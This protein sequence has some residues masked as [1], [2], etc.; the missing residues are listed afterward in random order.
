[1]N[2]ILVAKQNNNDDSYI[3]NDIIKNNSEVKIGDLLFTLETSKAVIDVESD[4]DGFILVNPNIDNESYWEAAAKLRWKLT[5]LEQ[6][7]MSWKNAY[8]ER[9]LVEY[10]MSFD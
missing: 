5:R 8:V 10:L 1:M 7:G 3:I 4:D 6:H 9:N 2:K